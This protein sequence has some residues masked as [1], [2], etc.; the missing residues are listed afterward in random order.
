MKRVSGVA[1]RK[2]I[3]VREVGV[4]FDGDNP[5]EQA[6]VGIPVVSGEDGKRGMWVAAHVAETQ[7]A[8]V[9]VQEDAT[10]LPVVPGRHGVRRPI[11][12]N[13]SDDRRIGPGQELVHFGW[14]GDGRHQVSSRRL[15]Q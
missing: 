12:A 1:D 9:H 11:Q 10:V 15:S 7:P 8:L 14:D 3:D 5:A 6:D 4:V 2:P 13:G